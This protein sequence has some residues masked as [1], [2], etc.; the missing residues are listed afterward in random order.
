MQ[1]LKLLKNLTKKDYL[2]FLEKA[3]SCEKSEIENN[4]REALPDDVGFIK[5]DGIGALRPYW[6]F[7]YL[8]LL[9][10]LNY[11]LQCLLIWM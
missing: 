3:N 6:G 4:I 8:L 1:I 5:D 10:I 7:I 11:A 2:Y 9:L